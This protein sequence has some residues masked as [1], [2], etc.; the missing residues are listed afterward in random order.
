MPENTPQQGKTNRHGPILFGLMAFGVLVPHGYPLLLN[1]V[2]GPAMPPILLLRLLVWGGIVYF[3][4]LGYLG[5]RWLILA[6]VAL[7]AFTFGWEAVSVMRLGYTVP[8]AT[9]AALALAQVGGAAL[10][11]GSGALRDWL[12]ARRARRVGKKIESRP[13]DA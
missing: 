7:G 2:T 13:E 1:L 12:A 8:A 9:F 4:Y 5:A 10:L 11:F 6:G 3:L